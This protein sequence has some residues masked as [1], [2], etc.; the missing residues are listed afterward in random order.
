M[1]Q[2]QKFI[3]INYSGQDDIDIAPYHGKAIALDIADRHAPYPSIFIIH[4]MRVRGY[5]PFHNTG[6]DVPNLDA[7]NWQDWV[8]TSGVWDNTTNQFHREPLGP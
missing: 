8:I 7:I 3:L 4:E 5:H 2:I 6:P 1:E